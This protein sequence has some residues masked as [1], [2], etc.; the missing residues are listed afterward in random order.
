[1]DHFTT[2]YQ[3]DY[4]WPSRRIQHA[5]P[6][7]RD[8]EH[9]RCDTGSRELKVIELCGD[10]QSWSRTGPMGRLLDPKLYPAK[11]G[12]HPESEVT[13]FDQPN[14]YLRKLEEK[15]PNLYGILKSSTEDEIIHRVDQ[16][17]LKT[18]YQVDYGE[19]GDA[20]MQKRI[21]SDIDSEKYKKN[22]RPSARAELI[23][24]R[25]QRDEKSKAK[26]L[27]KKGEEET[28][29]TRPPPWR[30]EYQDSISKLGS[31]IMNLR[32]HQR[33]APA[34]TWAMVVK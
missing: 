16:D 7:I 17:R 4:I 27:K 15:H 14:T 29:E 2:T 1:M 34:P 31:A 13:K 25:S 8:G 18:T 11:T 30:S 6:T 33:K 12:P 3:K 24:K 28:Q 10:Q 21:E 5:S 22:G 26:T 19:K 32:I 23:K 20:T 9:C